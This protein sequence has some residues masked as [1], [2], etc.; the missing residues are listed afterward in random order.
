MRSPAQAIAPSDCVRLRHPYP[1]QDNRG[2]LG[3]FNKLGDRLLHAAHAARS[4]TV[5]NSRRNIEE[6]YG[7]WERLWVR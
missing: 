3:L 1:L 5:E 2:L 7:E 4:N 6:H